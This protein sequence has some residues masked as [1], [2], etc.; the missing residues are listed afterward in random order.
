M[1]AL[2]GVDAG[3][4]DSWRAAGRV[5][6]LSELDARISI[7]ELSYVATGGIQFLVGHVYLDPDRSDTS[8][9]VLR[10]GVVWLPLRGRVTIDNRFMIER[11]W[12]GGDRSFRGRDRLRLSWSTGGWPGLGLYGSYEGFIDNDADVVEHRYQAGVTRR[13]ARATAETYWVQRRTR[14]GFVSN[15]LGLTVAWRVG[16]T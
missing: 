5:G 4:G 6:Y 2:V 16:G 10:S 15:S 11:R 9:S 3:L 14:A 8:T 12:V 13:I 1:W 7:L